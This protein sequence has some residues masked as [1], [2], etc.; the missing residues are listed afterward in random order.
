MYYS[1][2]GNRI[3][4]NRSTQSINIL[5]GLVMSL[6]L[7]LSGQALTYA[8]GGN[9]AALPGDNKQI[10]TGTTPPCA[11]TTVDADSVVQLTAS[12]NTNGDVEYTIGATSLRGTLTNCSS[13]FQAYYIEFSEAPRTTVDALNQP[14]CQ[15]TWSVGDYLMKSGDR[16]GWSFSVQQTLAP[17]TDISDCKG[18]HTVNARVIDRTTGVLLQQT[19]GAYTVQVK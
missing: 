7:A 17:I 3:R 2:K 5:V 12:T 8:K 18:T 10:V 13:S 19:V 16:K 11:T 15:L 4:A 14:T 9:G 6:I 1:I